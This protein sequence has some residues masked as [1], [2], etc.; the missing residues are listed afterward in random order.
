[1]SAPNVM[2]MG[3]RATEHKARPGVRHSAHYEKHCQR[4]T[5]AAMVYGEPVL[6]SR[7]SWCLT[8]GVPALSRILYSFGLQCVE[9]SARGLVLLRE[10]HRFAIPH[11]HER[12][13]E[14][15]AV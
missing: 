3:K 12:L 8:E 2:T 4:C 6:P 15:T 13:A 7:P 10:P 1:M 5:T 14:A 11:L 9:L